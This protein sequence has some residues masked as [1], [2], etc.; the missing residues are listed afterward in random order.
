MMSDGNERYFEGKEINDASDSP[1]EW[2]IYPLSEGTPL[3][4][5]DD[6]KYMVLFSDKATVEWFKQQSPK[7]LPGLEV[8]K[9]VLCHAGVTWWQWYVKTGD[10]V[11]DFPDDDLFYDREACVESTTWEE[12]AHEDD[13]IRVLES[14][15]RFEETGYIS[16][17]C[18]FRLSTEMPRSV[19]ARDVLLLLVTNKRPTSVL[20]IFF[21]VTES[22][23]ARDHTYWGKELPED[24][25][26][27]RIN[28]YRLISELD[29]HDIDGDRIDEIKSQSR[30]V[31][32]SLMI[33][34]DIP[35]F[36]KNADLEYLEV[37]K[38]FERLVGLSSEEILLRSDEELWGKEANVQLARLCAS[39]LNGESVQQEHVRSI[40]GEPHVFFDKVYPEWGF[41]GRISGVQG[42]M[43]CIG[44][45]GM[46]AEEKELPHRKQIS[47]HMR[48]IYQKLHL[49]AQGNCMVLLTG[50]SGSGKDFFARRIHELSKR[51]NEPFEILNCAALPE[52]LAESELFGYE[53]GAFTGTKGRKRGRL[54]IAG[55]GTLVLD[56]IGDMPLPLQTKLLTFLDTRCFKRLGGEKDI[57]CRARIIATTNTDLKKAV[58]EG[59]FRKDLYYR[60]NVFSMQVPPLRQRLE[61][62][63]SIMR[64][65]LADLAKRME[66]ERI[67]QIDG[68]AMRKLLDYHWPGNVRELTN[69]LERA[70]TH[71]NG[72]NIGV[73]HI[74]FDTEE[75]TASLD[76]HSTEHT[77]SSESEQSPHIPQ[78]RG[79]GDFHGVE[80]PNPSNEFV[81]AIYED[82]IVQ[83]GGSS[84]DV[85]K[86]YG[87]TN[88]AVRWWFKR[89]GLTK[90][91]A[92]RP[93]KKRAD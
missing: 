51:V 52:S 55:M 13:R 86:R 93:K 80:L 5:P 73:E 39:A 76:D 74:V 53:P 64:V 1:S 48:A 34:S 9:L 49:A 91:K 27:D 75:E 40:N 25:A 6:A 44:P 62:F 85:A 92:G 66:L 63:P 60:I 20:G 84:T 31:F 22:Q 12:L 42:I 54:E 47:P 81:R 35:A 18:S 46:P 79:E 57:Q 50:E 61:E 21:D 71:A 38:A 56:E 77:P 89:A 19:H 4:P 29:R 33:L 26:E 87:V 65:L 8:L 24:E 90:R 45:E 68:F 30:G 11:T 36:R 59:R 15:Q 14:V 7:E 37:N 2:I 82:Y 83:R 78:E 88:S 70:I 28:W 10:L 43:F 3:S 41:D 72:A 17:D 32:S 23:I 69:V 67:P 16:F 58:A